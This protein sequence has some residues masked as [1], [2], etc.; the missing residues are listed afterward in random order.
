MKKIIS[1]AVFCALLG[2]CTAQTVTSS[3]TK[4]ISRINEVIDTLDGIDVKLDSVVKI[5]L[6]PCLKPEKS[7]L[8]NFEKLLD[9]W[10]INSPIT[11]ED[12]LFKYIKLVE[13]YGEY[14]NKYIGYTTWECF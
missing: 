8:D 5:M 9:I 7:T 3:F 12:F 6:T 11:E 10:K 1:T 14:V 4:K 13:I 2:I